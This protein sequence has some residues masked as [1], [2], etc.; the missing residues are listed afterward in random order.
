MATYF[1]FG[2][3]TLDALDEISAER[4]ENAAAII[5]DCGGKLEAVYA[6]LG[7]T[8]LVLITDFPSTAAVMKASIAL[9]SELGIAFSSA[10]ALKAAEFDKLFD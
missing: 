10:P 2:S 6:L 7:D 3:Y 4:T 1:M 9:S 5:G 8:D